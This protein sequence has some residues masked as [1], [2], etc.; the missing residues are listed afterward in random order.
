M[1]KNIFYSTGHVSELRADHAVS[2]SLDQRPPEVSSTPN[3][4][5]I[6]QVALKNYF[7]LTSLS[8]AAASEKNTA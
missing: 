2:R 7:L 8:L 5:F 1:E 4:L 3:Y 6:L